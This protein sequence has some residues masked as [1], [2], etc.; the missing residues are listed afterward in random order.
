MEKPLRA[1]TKIMRQ[2][3][4]DNYI[5]RKEHESANVVRGCACKSPAHARGSTDTCVLP[6]LAK[7][8]KKEL[9]LE[10]QSFSARLIQKGW[11]ACKYAHALKIGVR[12]LL[13]QARAQ[14]LVDDE[15]H[16]NAMAKKI[17]NAWQARYAH[18]RVLGRAASDGLTHSFGTQRVSRA[19]GRPCVVAVGYQV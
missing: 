9:A 16:R 15:R 10:H 18:G 3:A 12:N 17:Q 6:Q 7:R 4:R 13:R 11:K 8:R 2:I 19:H 1:T 14:A 5:G